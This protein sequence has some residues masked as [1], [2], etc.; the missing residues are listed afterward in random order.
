MKNIVVAVSGGVDSVVLLDYVS[1]RWDKDNIIVAHFEHGI[2]DDSSEDLDFVNCLAKIYGLKFEFRR[3]R[4]GK[5]CSE[6]KARQARYDFLRNTAAKY[7]ADIVTAHHINDLAETIAINIHRGTGW[8]GLACLN[9]PNIVRPFLSIDKN[10]ILTYA[11]K[12]G[13]EWR[14]DSTNSSDKYLRNSLRFKMKKLDIQ[15]NK[16]YKLWEKQTSLSEKI[17]DEV[18]KILSKIKNNGRYSR[19][20]FSQIDELTACEIIKHILEKETGKSVLKTQCLDFW[21]KIKTMPQNKKTQVLGGKNVKFS[22][23][24]FW[25]E[26]V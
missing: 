4:L 22:K 6:L 5:K 11:M 10:N 7:N 18:S 26:K 16:L 14:E 24:E 21:I 23:R 2:R 25:F 20:F 8:R 9:S 3:G 19:Y 1:E 15:Y 12:N 17:D 13:L